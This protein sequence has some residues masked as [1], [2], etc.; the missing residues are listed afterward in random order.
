MQSPTCASTTARAVSV[1]RPWS[2]SGSWSRISPFGQSVIEKLLHGA[3]RVVIVNARRTLCRADDVGNLFVRQP[4]TNPKA[5][6]L[7]LRRRQLLHRLAQA[8]FG[9]AG[10][11]RIERI[12]LRGR[13]AFL[14]FNPISASLFRA[15]P[16]EQ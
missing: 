1:S 13:V 9:F 16:I 3:H 12:I 11:E 8:T 14:Y 5:E 15:P 4:L 6:H 2:R 7:A 10:D